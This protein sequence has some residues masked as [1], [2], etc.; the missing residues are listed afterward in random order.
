MH[1]AEG[2]LLTQRA[3]IGRGFV[4]VFDDVMARFSA[5]PE[6]AVRARCAAGASDVAVERHGRRVQ[7][8]GQILPLGSSRWLCPWTAACDP[9]HGGQGGKVGAMRREIRTT[10]MLLILPASVAVFVELAVLLPP[11]LGW[12]I[13]IAGA[14]GLVCWL[15][16]LVIEIFD[17][18]PVV[19]VRFVRSSKFL[20]WAAFILALVAAILMLVLGRDFYDWVVV[21]QGQQVAAMVTGE[22]EQ[23]FFNYTSGSY[24]DFFY[25]LARVSD[26]ADLGWTTHGELGGDV[27]HRIGD[28]VK[29]F[30]GPG[31]SLVII[32]DPGAVDRRTFA[33]IRWLAILI[34]ATLTAVWARGGLEMRYVRRGFD[35]ASR[36]S[37]Q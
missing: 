36:R 19:R 4:E 23:G 35:R 13:V 3:R 25:R 5:S 27:V 29:S 28:H 7:Q 8:L 30:V 21:H 20:A 2:L 31:S 12:F 32:D 24:T 9:C 22:R 33:L 14:F 34:A 18:E 17:D 15:M 10:V 6:L 37:C 1:H 11:V 26:G 16:V